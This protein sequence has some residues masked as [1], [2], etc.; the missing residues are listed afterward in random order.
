MSLLQFVEKNSEFCIGKLISYLT[1]RL[2]LNG[3]LLFMLNVLTY[4]Q[5]QSLVLFLF[6]SI[7]AIA[8]LVILFVFRCPFYTKGGKSIKF[9]EGR[10]TYSV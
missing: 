4:I 10:D 5:A 1:H 3:C 8:N 9:K 2:N 7:T 6:P